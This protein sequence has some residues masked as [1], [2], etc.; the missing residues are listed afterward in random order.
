V[1]E[2]MPRPSLP[3][4]ILLVVGG[5]VGLIA[6]FALTLDKIAILENPDFV[7]GCNVSVLV[8]CSK[9]LNSEVGSVFGFPNPLLGLMMFPA[10]LIV[11]VASIAGVR[12][13]RWFWAVFTLGMAFAIGFVIY[14]ISNSI[15]NLELRVLCPWCMAV[16]SVVIP[17]S[18]ATTLYNLR[19]G[20]IP[21]GARV[22]KVAGALYGWLPILTLVCY[23]IFLVVAQVNLDLVNNLFRR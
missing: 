10:P 23:V 4:A 5:M 21:L 13:P 19:E 9:N 7:P 3:L 17:M 11:G 8:G 2:R 18:L 22:A 16:W 20:A 15:F 1:I 14:L 12:F 6:A